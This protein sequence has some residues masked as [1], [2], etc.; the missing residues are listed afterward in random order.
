MLGK[1]LGKKN[2]IEHLYHKD[3]TLVSLIGNERVHLLILLE[4]LIVHFYCKRIVLKLDKRCKRMAVPQIKGV[5]AI[6]H[7][8]IQV[9]HPQFL[10]VE[11]R[12]VVRSV[13]IFIYG[14][15]R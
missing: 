13:R 9:L 11:P 8:H 3:T 7:K 14:T 5:H 1:R 10:I 15:S 4:S 6:G 2:V 12:E